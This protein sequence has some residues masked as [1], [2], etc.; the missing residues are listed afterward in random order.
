[1]LMSSRLSV[2]PSQWTRS[3]SELLPISRLEKAGDG[4]DEKRED[5]GVEAKRKHAVHQR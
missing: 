4:V 2:T 3:A 1:M 5:D